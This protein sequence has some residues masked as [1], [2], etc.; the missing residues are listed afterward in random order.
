MIVSEE[1]ENEMESKTENLKS[2]LTGKIT[3]YEN[4]KTSL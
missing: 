4:I 3:S 1:N 2:L